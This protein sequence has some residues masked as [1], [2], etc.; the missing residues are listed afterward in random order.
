MCDNIQAHGGN[1]VRYI[2][3]LWTQSIA[4]HL[5]KVW[6][7]ILHLNVLCIG[8]QSAIVNCTLSLVAIPW[9]YLLD[10]HISS[11]WRCG[12]GACATC[13]GVTNEW[14]HEKW[15]LWCCN[16]ACCD[17]AW[18]CISK[19]ELVRPIPQK[20]RQWCWLSQL[21]KWTSKRWLSTPYA[22]LLADNSAAGS[23]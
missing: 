22:M 3:G 14:A 11:A 23:Q 21:Q 1:N 6:L 16:V 20:L 19:Q 7:I 2:L 10:K 4:H 13:W 12:T 8:A 15:S 9:N 5:R 17:W 18:S